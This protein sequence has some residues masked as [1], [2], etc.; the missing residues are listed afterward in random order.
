LI[1]LFFIL[2]EKPP[3]QTLQLTSLCYQAL[4]ISLK[5]RPFLAR[6]GIQPPVR[7]LKF[8]FLKPYSLIAPLIEGETVMADLLKINM[9]LEGE[10]VLLVVLN[11]GVEN[12]DSEIEQAVP[13][14]IRADKS[15]RAVVGESTRVPAFFNQVGDLIVRYFQPEDFASFQQALDELC[16]AH[17]GYP[18]VVCWETEGEGQMSA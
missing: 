15:V 11:G 13:T 14:A 4:P 2:L 8:P 17:R 12:T 18:A 16:Y 6:H 5:I 1:Y 3:K 10:K 9:A 7:D